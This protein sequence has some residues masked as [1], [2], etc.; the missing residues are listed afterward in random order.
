[1][2]QLIELLVLL[3]GT[4]VLATFF[5]TYL[6][7]MI[8]Y[9]NRPIEKTLA[10]VENKFYR[11]IGIDV[12]RQMSW[13]EYFS[14]LFI[15]NMIVVVVIILILVF[16]NYLPF[17]NNVEGFSLDLAVHTA[18]SFI[19]GTN[20]QHYAGDQ[21]LSNLSQMLAITFTMF[22][23]PASGIATAFAFIRSFIRK[24]FGLGNFYMDFI[25][26]ILTLLLP[27]SFISALILM[28]IGVPQ[29]LDSSITITPLE[30]ALYNSN[31]TTITETTATVGP[32]ASLESI[33]LLGN[34][35]GGFFG[36]NSA[37]AF[38]NPTGLSNLYEMFL[39]LIIP[40]SFPIAYAKLMGLG[41]GL[42]ILVTMLI[43]FGVLLSFSLTSENGPL[44]LETRFGSFGS[45]LFD[46]TSLGTNSGA[47]NSSLAG[48]SSNA[49]TSFFLAMF[50]QAIPGAGG[51][52]MM[53]MII[54]VLLTLFIVGL[55]VGKS[56][57]FMSMKISPRDIKL[58]VFIFLLHP[59]NILIPTV[60]AFT[61]GNA[62]AIVGEQVTAM[63]FTQTLYE[64]TS[65]AANNGSD[66]FGTAADTPFWNWSTA[67]VMFLGRYVPIG[68]ML[69]IAGS[70]TLKDRKE[71][72]EPIKTKGPL[73]ISIL[74]VMTFLLTALSF[75]PFLIMGPISI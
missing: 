24:N 62:Q 45:P 9:E 43:G 25:R 71:V 10:I 18:I 36:S 46:T 23:A 54:Y 70:F 47:V 69:A 34:N 12:S 42:S 32:I 33:K 28:M 2:E 8:S 19:T 61:T 51:T 55:M 37:H 27:V 39:M 68:L 35:G 64:Y 41:R 40:L 72:I 20:L 11:L 38:E 65:A 16:Q 1:L 5:G 15:T 57:E 26:V 22:V 21:Q 75:F 31:N 60:I 50:V 48:M 30:S 17:S 73:F 6:A 49:V 59:A 7:R 66:Y 58:A 29:T 52:G 4:L 14:A 3:G 53:T 67:I 56:P 74:V 63:G 44:L 13:K